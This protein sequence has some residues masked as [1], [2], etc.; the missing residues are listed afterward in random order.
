MI[1]LDSKDKSLE[2][3]LASI[4]TTSELPVVA[5]FN[6]LTQSNFA[7]TNSSASD[8]VTNGTTAVTVVAAP[9]SGISRQL[10]YLSVE[11]VDTVTATV[12]VRLNNA[13]ALRNTV[14]TELMPGQSLI[15]VDAAG[16]AVLP[17]TL[18][19]SMA[20]QDA[21]AVSISGGLIDGNM[22]VGGTWTANSAL[23]LPSHSNS[24]NVDYD[25]DVI[26]NT[27]GKKVDLT[28]G[29]H[30]IN[31]QT[32]G[33]VAGTIQTQVGAT[34]LTTTYNYVDTVGTVRDGVA[35]SSTPL[36]NMLQ[37]V[38]NR[39]AQSAQVWPAS[40]AAIDGGAP[41]AADSNLLSAGRARTYVYAGSSI[42]N[43]V[44]NS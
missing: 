14:R 31:S 13:S 36:V 26:L 12:I 33:I 4:V 17:S 19:G 5:S 7:L 9:S 8:T 43:T 18:F 24:G 3:V 15:Y 37:I 39:G 35:L 11:N 34:A 38:V 10:K 23:R 2:V 16:W 28:V 1:I 30:I 29:G 21:D 20:L 25:G 41:D 6:D 32:V 42:W 40:G 44:S 27:A 22:G